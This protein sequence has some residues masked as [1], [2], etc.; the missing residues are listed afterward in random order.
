L[1]L[2][3]SYLAN[4]GMHNSLVEIAADAVD[5]REIIIERLTTEQRRLFG[6]VVTLLPN[7]DDAE[8]AFQET[9]I[10]IWAKAD[11]YDASRD[12]L[13]WAC[14]FARNVAHEMRE[15]NRCR[16]HA[17]LSEQAME[18]LAQTRFKATATQNA[19]HA[20]LSECLGRLSDVQRELLARCYA[21]V[22]AIDAIAVQVQTSPAALYMKLMRIRR[23]LA[24]CL[25]DQD[26]AE[27]T[28]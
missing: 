16:N 28:R 22:E 2:G 5:N 4:G 11:Q 3:W 19:W 9:C 15:K 23:Q 6:Y 10:R 7:F 21:G 24:K 12:F 13:S 27:V 26:D 17:M 20:K 1:L 8:D 25:E 14:G 18:A